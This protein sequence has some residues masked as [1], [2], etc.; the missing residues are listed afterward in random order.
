[1]RFVLS[2]LLATSAGAQPASVTVIK[3]GTLIDG[4]SS[5]VRKNQTIVIRGN[6]IESVGGDVTTPA[7]ARVIDLS[8][9]TVLPGMIDTHTHIFLQGEDPAEGGYDIQLLKY[10]LAYRA[11][12]AGI[13]T[14]ILLAIARISGETAPLLFTALNNQFWS[15]NLNAPMA[16]L[17]AVIFQFA[18]S[19]YAD[20][21]KLAWVGALIITFAVLTLSVLARWLGKQG[22]SQ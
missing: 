12:R 18:L 1:M 7:G 17:P 4:R 16:S 9:M 8:N 11:A 6:R 15:T 20:W 2:L 13:V 10:P 21:Q 5:E 22:A 3:A 19:P 14:G